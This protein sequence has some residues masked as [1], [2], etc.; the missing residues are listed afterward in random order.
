MATK[1]EEL[2][3]VRRQLV[4]WASH[5]LRTP[6][7]SLQAMVEALEDGLAA[8]ADYLPR[9]REQVRALGM[10]VDDLFELARIDAGAL[11]LELEDAPLSGLVESTACAASSPRRPR[12]RSAC[13]R[14]WT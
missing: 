6:I 7:A 4:A 11:T 9:M 12:G 8:P 2:F 1:L 14:A 10:L 5:D 13:R 3:D